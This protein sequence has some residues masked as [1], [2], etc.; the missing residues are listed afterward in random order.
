MAIK[1]VTSPEIENANLNV[2]WEAISGFIG[3]GITEYGN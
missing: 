3:L 2:E 1:F